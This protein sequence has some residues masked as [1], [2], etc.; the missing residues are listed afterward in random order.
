MTFA[1]LAHYILISHPLKVIKEKENY[2]RFFL[3][4]A[5]LI[6]DEVQNLFKPLP[7]QKHEHNALKNFLLDYN[8]KY[9]KNLQL[10][11]LSATPGET[12]EEVVELLNMIR[13]KNSKKIIVPNLNDQIEINK[14]AKSI[15]GLVSYFDIS[16]D[17]SKYPKVI[18]EEPE[19]L[20]MSIIQ[21]KKYVEVFN[22][23]KLIDKDYN[24]LLKNEKVENYYKGP[25]KYSNMLLNFEKDM[26]LYEFSSKMPALIQNIKKFPNEKH[27]IYSK[28]FANIGYG[29]NGILS[30]A[31][32]LEKELGYEKLDFKKARALNTENKLPSIKRRYSLAITNE[33]QDKQYSNG[34]NLSE[35]VKLYN[36]SEN[37][38]GQYVHLF[39]ASQ[40]YN[41]GVD[42]KAIRHIHILEPLL[43]NNKKIQ[44]IGRASRYC[45]HK[46]LNFPT[47]WN[48]TVHEYLADFPIETKKWDLNSMKNKIESL[49]NNIN[50]N[51]EILLKY[52]G[53]RGSEIKIIREKLQNEILENKKELIIENKE[54]KEYEKLDPKKVEMIDIKITQEVKD[55]LK[56]LLIINQILRYV[57]IDCKLFRKFHMQTT[58]NFAKQSLSLRKCFND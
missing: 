43:S 24:K 56:N 4:N 39:L 3:D 32:I 33:L 52:K 28:F 57:S 2:H 42:F 40:N 31:K 49:N 9:S 26:T 6:I 48:V 29:G 30:I 1:Q 51:E 23:V 17:V 22:E 34:E 47:E 27:Y 10:V 36:K 54:L 55:R 12:I 50:Q 25:R 58:D 8:N 14:F 18:I 19:I 37:S 20:P 44:T 5:I 41:E 38:N 21:Y 46:D 15:T 13:D 53:K 45:S 35:L 7:N 16:S 11:I